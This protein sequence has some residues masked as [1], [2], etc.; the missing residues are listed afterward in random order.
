MDQHVSALFATRDESSLVGIEAIRALAGH[1]PPRKASLRLDGKAAEVSAQDVRSRGRAWQ[2]SCHT[3]AQPDC[4][5][6]SPG[7][8]G[9]VFEA[10]RL[11][12]AGPALTERNGGAWQQ[13]LQRHPGT[14]HHTFFEC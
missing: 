3:C 7:E 4:A 5:K 10:C 13:P 6:P 12:S 1:F 2:A 11:L 9:I 8:S 14:L